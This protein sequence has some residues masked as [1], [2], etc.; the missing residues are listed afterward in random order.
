[1]SDLS[2]VE[3]EVWKGYSPVGEMMSKAIAEAAEYYNMRVPF[4]GDYQI[5]LNW[6]HCH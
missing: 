2:H 4:D 5:G 6:L 3:D 1:M